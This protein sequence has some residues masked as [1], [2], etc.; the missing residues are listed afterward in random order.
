M[1]RFSAFLTIFVITS[2]SA[3]GTPRILAIDLWSQIEALNQSSCEAILSAI[4]QGSLAYRPTARQFS[5]DAYTWK[6]L[7]AAELI[8]PILAQHSPSLLGRIRIS[9]MLQNTSIDADEIHLRQEAIKE[10]STNPD[11]LFQ[12][13]TLLATFSKRNDENEMA[14]F[15]SQRQSIPARGMVMEGAG[16]LMTNLSWIGPLSLYLSTHNLEA[17]AAMTGV[18]VFMALAMQVTKPMAHL[19]HLRARHQTVKR[20]LTTSENARK[21]LASSRSALLQEIAKSFAP[22]DP[23]KY[24]SDQNRMVRRYL[25]VQEGWFGKFMDAIGISSFTVRGMNSNLEQNRGQLIRIGSAFSELAALAA[26]AKYAQGVNLFY[27][28]ILDENLPTQVRIVQGHHPYI[29]TDITQTSIPN[30]IELS[31]ARDSKQKFIL[32]TG[33]NTG[34]KSTALRMIG[35]NILLGQMGAPIPVQYAEWT[36]MAVLSNMNVN[37]S[38]QDRASFFKAQVNRVRDIFTQMSQVPHALILMD[39]IF[40][41]TSPE[42]HEGGERAVVDY[43]MLTGHV[44][45]LATH[46]RSLADL[47]VKY[48]NL[49]NYRVGEEG[50]PRYVI[51]PGVSATRNALAVMREA[52]LPNDFLEL[53]RQNTN[54]GQP[55]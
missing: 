52:G 43:L 31:S 18:S 35:T 33:V 48:P 17:T 42:E 27:P 8:F 26:L 5:V 51:Q 37:D 28:K 19:A 40:T 44:A 29:L 36:P 24:E 47:N 16:A 4:P 10:L 11:L 23:L 54:L 20:M 34:G 38:V 6:D 9:H 49:Q 41:G 46:D 25:R 50:Q 30:T 22:F 53:V 45:I 21:A 2:N 3:F 13:Q 7:N 1:R 39:E 12:L 14:K 32:L 55:K 15:L